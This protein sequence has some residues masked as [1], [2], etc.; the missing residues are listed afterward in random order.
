MTDPGED[1]PARP[2][3]PLVP[4]V[5]PLTAFP[6]EPDDPGHLLPEEDWQRIEADAASHRRGLQRVAGRR[7]CPA[8]SAPGCT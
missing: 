6:P 5:R 3:A 2:E 4:G 8:G 7:R 1:T